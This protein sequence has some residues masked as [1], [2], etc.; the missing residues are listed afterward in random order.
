GETD[1]ETNALPRSYS[2]F[3]AQT[4]VQAN[5]SGDETTVVNV[6]YD[7]NSYTLN[8]YGN[9]GSNSM[10][11]VHVS[12]P[13]IYGVETALPANLFT[14]TGYSFE[15]WATTLARANAGTVDYAEGAYY[16]IG[17]A[18]A[19]LYAVWRAN[20]VS[21]SIEV[22]D[23]GGVGITKTEAENI[24]T[25]TATLPDGADPGDYTY[26]WFDPNSGGIGSP[27]CITYIYEIDKST[28]ATGTYQITLIATEILSGIPSGGT[29]QIDVE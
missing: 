26:V 16:T 7:R 4:P 22:P 9:G 25:F 21:I 28:L 11:S 3:T 2:G 10:G 15:G 14:R 19:S 24:I 18:N 17:A 27:A 29:I 1:T 23:S 13:C 5:I 6:Y 8:L 20:Q 12:N